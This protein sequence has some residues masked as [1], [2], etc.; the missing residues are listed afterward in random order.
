MMQA[1]NF[2]KRD[3]R[4]G[5]EQVYRTGLRAVLVE[6]QM[7]SRLVVISKWENG[8]IGN[9]LGCTLSD[10]LRQPSAQCQRGRDPGRAGQGPNYYSPDLVVPRRTS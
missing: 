3:D 5:G 1:T 6:R 2:R 7:R 10:L 4:A 8:W 9:R